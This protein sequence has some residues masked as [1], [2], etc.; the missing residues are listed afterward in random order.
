MGVQDSA[1][2]CSALQRAVLSSLA[3]LANHPECEQKQVHAPDR[4]T[5][6]VFSSA[7]LQSQPVVVA[8][9]GVVGGASFMAG[10][11]FH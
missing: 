1:A 3:L 7:F 5:S 2:C 6:L 4:L 10:K 9:W 11:G 8:V